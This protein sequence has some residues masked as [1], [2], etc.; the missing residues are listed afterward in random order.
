MENGLFLG[1]SKREN[2]LFLGAGWLKEGKNKKARIHECCPVVEI[3]K[4]GF[5][6]FINSLS[7]ILNSLLARLYTISEIITSHKT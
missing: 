1:I 5:H 2:S 6:L 3:S 4:C 7:Y